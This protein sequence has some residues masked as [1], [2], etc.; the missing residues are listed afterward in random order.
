MEEKKL[1][2][3]QETPDCQELDNDALESTSGGAGSYGPCP[4][5]K[6]MTYRDKHCTKCGFVIIIS[7]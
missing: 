4:R 1:D 5:C 6:Q 2:L 7:D 3:T